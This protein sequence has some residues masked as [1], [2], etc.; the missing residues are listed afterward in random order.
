MHAIVHL[1][2]IASIT[3]STV[4]VSTIMSES[5]GTEVNPREGRAIT[6][7]AWWLNLKSPN[8]ETNIANYH[9][10]VKNGCL[11]EYVFVHPQHKKVHTFQYAGDNVTSEDCLMLSAA[12]D[13]IKSRLWQYTRDA[14]ENCVKVE[15]KALGFIKEGDSFDHLIK[16]LEKLTPEEVEAKKQDLERLQDVLHRP[17]VRSTFEGF[18]KQ[19][20]IKGR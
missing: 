6:A 14:A 19:E 4:R 13:C 2:S 15:A 18:Q 12:M 16:Y 9:S 10:I 20:N 8:V 7:H 3:P 17:F 5:P 1:F 11:N